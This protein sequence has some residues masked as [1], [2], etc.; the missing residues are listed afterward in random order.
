MLW[1]SLKFAQKIICSAHLGFTEV[2]SQN[3]VEYVSVYDTDQ[4]RFFH[5]IISFLEF[6]GRIWLPTVF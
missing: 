2:L 4:V 1:P 5:T 6:L 3:V